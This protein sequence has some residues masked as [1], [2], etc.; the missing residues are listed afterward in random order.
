WPSGLRR[1]IKAPIR[2]GAGSNPARITI[3]FSK[4]QCLYILRSALAIP[5][6]LVAD[7]PESVSLG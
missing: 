7:R 6:Q 2:K 3:V 1:R 5:Q 4:R